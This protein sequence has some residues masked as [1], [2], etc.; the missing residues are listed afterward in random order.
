[1]ISIL[2][3]IAVGTVI[4][5]VGVYYGHQLGHVKGQLLEAEGRKKTE[6]YRES[7]YVQADCRACGQINRLPWQRLRD[8]PVCGKCKARLLPKA[9]VVISTCDPVLNREL[10]SV[11]DNYEKVWELVADAFD[12]LSVT[13]V[14]SS[15]SKSKPRR[16]VN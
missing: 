4:C 15:T 11:W 3:G 10:T 5:A 7:G 14:S 6:F 12:R 9:R 1:M 8:K 16:W 2:A 13:S